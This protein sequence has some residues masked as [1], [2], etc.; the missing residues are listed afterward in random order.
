MN[1][2]V[3]YNPTKV[4]FGDNAELE[5]SHELQNFRKILVIYGSDRIEKSGLLDRVKELIKVNESEVFYLKGIESNPKSTK[6]YEGIEICK[7]QKIDFLLAVGGGSAIDTAKAIAIGAQTEVDFFDFFEGK[8]QANSALPL[9][10]ILTISGAGSETNSGAVITHVEK[11]K[12]L[13]YGSNFIFPKFVIMNP[14]FT[15]T[16]PVRLTKAGIV[17]SISHIF[18]RYFSNTPYTRCL[19][20]MSEG[21]LKTLFFYGDH[22]EENI[23]EYQMRA[24]LMWASK[25]AQDNY[26]G[27]GKKQ[28]W[29]SHIISHELAAQYDYVHG[30]L[31]AVIFPAW[32]K[33]N[34]EIAK[35]KLKQIGKYVFEMDEENDD[36]FTEKVIFHIENKY[37][38]WGLPTTLRDLGFN[39]VE[40]IEEMAINCVSL[41]PS[42]TI[43][44]F[45]RLNKEDVV[46]ILKIAF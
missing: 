25:I 29:A 36:N 9:G 6:V 40:K 23:D 2:F 39:D 31:L 24:E 45:R 44:N 33:Y 22:L 38:S 7:D 42:Q 18:E 34:S 43:G 10:S 19:D 26:L 41:M 4:Y 3:Y 17:D 32:I 20:E 1:S 30:E 14:K 27:V 8:Y 11:Q 37:K 13:S 16:V 15:A 35:D 5:L 46:S 12:K 21:L 28:D